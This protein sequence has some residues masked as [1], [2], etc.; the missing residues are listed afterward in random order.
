[1]L[2]YFARL[3]GMN[4]AAARRSATDLLD[5]MG[6]GERSKDALEKL[7]L[8]RQSAA[9]ATGRRPGQQP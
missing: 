3:H 6:L 4:A 7:S 1:Q 8:S 5:G 2:E 9:G